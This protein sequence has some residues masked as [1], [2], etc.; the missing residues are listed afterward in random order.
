MTIFAFLGE[1]V[2]GE[3]RKLYNRGIVDVDG[4]KQCGAG[5]QYGFWGI[6][7]A[8]ILPKIWNRFRLETKREKFC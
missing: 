3:M 4:G 6:I 1:E 5:R 2:L 8:P 7:E